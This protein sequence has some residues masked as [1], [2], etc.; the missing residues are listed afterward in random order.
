M[1]KQILLRSILLAA[2]LAA[3]PNLLL[4]NPLPSANTGPDPLDA[5]N[6]KGQLVI[7]GGALSSSNQVVY[8]RYI[9]LAG[10]ADQARIA[11]IPAASGQPV[12]Y[13]RQFQADLQRY[14]MA[15]QRVM[16]L[17]IAVKDDKLTAG[18]DESQWL[19]GAQNGELAADLSNF[20]GI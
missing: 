13:F 17:P 16:L 9:E 8:Q 4:A 15:P 20:S 18:T 14:G 12:K 1:N 2:T 10:G 3:A 6:A 19:H 11:V 7:V 5:A